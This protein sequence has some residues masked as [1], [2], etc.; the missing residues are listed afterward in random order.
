MLSQV[1]V[2]AFGTYVFASEEHIL[3]PD[4]AFVSLFLFNN[5]RFSL[6]F[7]PMIV[8]MMLKALVSLERIRKYLLCEEIH[9]EGVT[10]YVKE[11]K[12]QSAFREALD[13]K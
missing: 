12:F 13:T 2:A 11:C 7:L 8:T 10:H 5:M 9:K 4:R 6:T 1:A 3:T